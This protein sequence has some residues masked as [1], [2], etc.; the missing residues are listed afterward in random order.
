M[1]ALTAIASIFVFV[2]ALSISGVVQVANR[3]LATVRESVAAMRD[4]NLDDEKREKMVQQASIKLFSY[5]FSIL[6]RST[7][8]F[9][10]SFMPICI[11]S[12]FNLAEINEVIHYLA[13][14]DV[15]VIA[16]IL[17]VIGYVGWVRLRWFFR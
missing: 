4:S 6:I 7:L 8:V 17:I 12:L 1:I 14:W 10:F 15:I 5:F 3:V 11:S 9:L 2:F 13:R 16:T